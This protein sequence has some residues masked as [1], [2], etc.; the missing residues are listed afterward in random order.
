MKI[1]SIA[2]HWDTVTPSPSDK[3]GLCVRDEEGSGEF[4]EAVCININNPDVTL[5]TEIYE[6]QTCW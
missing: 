6:I 1:Y 4:Y 5:A 3:S 2:E